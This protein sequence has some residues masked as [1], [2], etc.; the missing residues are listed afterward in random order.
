MNPGLENVKSKEKKKRKGCNVIVGGSK[1]PY[2]I[3]CS[4]KYIKKK[5]KKKKEKKNCLILLIKINSNFFYNIQLKSKTRHVKK[6]KTIMC[7]LPRGGSSVAFF[8][9][10]KNGSVNY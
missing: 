1:N 10:K 6:K 2:R 4:N 3:T 7:T 8:P 9:K 5:K